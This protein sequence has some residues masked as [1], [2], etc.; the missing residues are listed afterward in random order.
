MRKAVGVIVG[1]DETVSAQ[2]MDSANSM[3]EELRAVAHA[4]AEQ[5]IAMA[6]A[7]QRESQGD[8]E[9]SGSRRPSRTI[10]LA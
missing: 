9:G 3:A 10:Q 7:A 1:I 2:A 4:E 6:R 8:S 5:A